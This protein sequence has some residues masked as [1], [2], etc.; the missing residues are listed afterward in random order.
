MELKLLCSG[1]VKLHSA[2]PADLSQI[3]TIPYLSN[4]RKREIEEFPSVLSLNYSVLFI[5][6]AQLMNA[7]T[8]MG[9]QS[10][11]GIIFCRWPPPFLPGYEMKKWSMSSPK[12][13]RIS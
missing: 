11:Q 4:E 5:T 2:L 12:S 9:R 1:S 7:S 8:F 3:V 6:L 13:S 10:W